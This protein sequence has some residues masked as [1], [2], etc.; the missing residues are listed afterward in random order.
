MD[1]T[2]PETLRTYLQRI[3]RVRLL[4]AGE[5]VA[6]AK[7]IERGDLAA[8]EHLVEANLRLVFSVAKCYVGRGLTLLDLIQ[9]G[10]VGLIRA[11]EKF[12]YRRGVKFSTYATWWI[13][14]A[15]SRAVADKSRT[16]RVPKHVADRIATVSH[17]QHQLVQTLGRDPTHA[18]V[19]REL[20][21]PTPTVRDLLRVSHQPISL[22][23]QVDGSNA[24]MLFDVVEDRA[25]ESP[26]ELATQSIRRDAVRQAVAR[27]PARERTIIE[28]RYGLAD[29]P[30]RSRHEVARALD[31]S[32]ERVRQIERQTLELLESLPEARPL[33]DCV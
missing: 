10:S 3:G 13:R 14:Q 4:T 15:V 27:L 6:L 22:H 7:R 23:T 17:V 19:A 32:S 8:K 2:D 5:E 12:D 29:P 1:T 16:I 30:A 28:L 31:L 26:F 25:A 11:T 21:W 33:Q 20:G 9:E 24:R 18:E